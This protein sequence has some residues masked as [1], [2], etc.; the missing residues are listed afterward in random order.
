MP[1]PETVAL[2]GIRFQ[3]LRDARGYADTIIAQRV[4]AIMPTF[5]ALKPSAF[6]NF[7]GGNH[8]L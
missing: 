1:D 8:P 2:R 3:I 6:I 7:G 4:G 5:T